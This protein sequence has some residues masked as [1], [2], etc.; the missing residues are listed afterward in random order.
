MSEF[1]ERRPPRARAVVCLGY[2]VVRHIEHK[3]GTQPVLAVVCEEC[4]AVWERTYR[5]VFRSQQLKRKMR[6]GECRGRKG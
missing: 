5:S 2:R 3:D 1:R 6:C 4:G